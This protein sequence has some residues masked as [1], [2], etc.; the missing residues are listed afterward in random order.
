M[1]KIDALRVFR[2]AAEL[3]NFT[4]VAERTTLS[5]SAISKAIQQLESELKLRLFNRTTRHISLTEGGETY[6]RHVCRILDDLDAADLSVSDCEAVPRGTLRISAPMTFTLITLTKRMPK[7]LDLY[8]ELKVD[9][10][11]DDHKRD[12]LGEGYDVAIRGN[13][14]G[15]PDSSLIAKRLMTMEHVLVASPD[16][17]AHAGKINHPD[18]INQHQTIQFSL[19]A[20]A[21][22]W[23]FTNGNET[24][25][26]PINGRY[27]VS[28]SLAVLDAIRAGIGYSLVPKIY[29]EDDLVSGKLVTVLDDWKKDETNVFALYPTK[30]YMPVKTR[31]FLDFLVELFKSYGSS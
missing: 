24:V 17:I 11:M 2:H 14:R 31:V 5:Q 13:T 19:T 23:T 29:I 25:K 22:L 28:S 10:K 4:K 15:I 7:F 20:H 16:Y 27:R 8:P 3:N 26:L 12:F 30:S 18:Q 1:D 9:L 6:Y 21:D